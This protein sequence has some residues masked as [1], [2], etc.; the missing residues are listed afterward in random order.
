MVKPGLA[1]ED[2]GEETTEKTKPAE[3]SAD[4][5][6]EDTTGDSNQDQQQPGKY[7]GF[8]RPQRRTIY[9]ALSRGMN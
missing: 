8:S 9:F 4:H 6:R 3:A 1:Q 2:G 5:H 7:D